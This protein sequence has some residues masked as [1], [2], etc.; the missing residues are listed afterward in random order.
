MVTS[1]NSSTKF[2]QHKTSNTPVKEYRPSN[3]DE[4][5]TIDTL[6][7]WVYENH[8]VPNSIEECKAKISRIKHTIADIDLQIEI[9]AAELASEGGSEQQ[10][11]SWKATALRAKQSQNYVLNAYSYWLELNSHGA[12]DLSKKFNMLVGLLVEDPVDFV[13]RA[14]ILLD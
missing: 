9:K 12:L 7:S 10:F 3:W 8:E 6:P 1:I 13:S 14:Q 4:F 2:A 11:N 5:E